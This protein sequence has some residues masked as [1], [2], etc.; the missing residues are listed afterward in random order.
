MPTLS[1]IDDDMDCTSRVTSPDS[2]SGKRSF[3]F[4]S[5]GD[6]IAKVQKPFSGLEELLRPSVLVDPIFEASKWVTVPD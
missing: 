3:L 5:D 2:G 6:R 1:H 4:S